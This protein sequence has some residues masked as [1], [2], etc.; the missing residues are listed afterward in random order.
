MAQ[1]L[2]AIGAMGAMGLTRAAD[3]RGGGFLVFEA[4][5]SR[6]HVGLLVRE[7]QVIVSRFWPAQGN[8]LVGWSDKCPFVVGAQVI[9]SSFWLKAPWANQTGT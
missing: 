9:L 3:G 7:A 1:R 4:L 5:G 2:G 8:P 6:L